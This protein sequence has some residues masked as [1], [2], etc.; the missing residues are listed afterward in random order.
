ML[1][2]ISGAMGGVIFRR[3]NKRGEAIIA[4]RPRKSNTQPSEAQKA[5]RERF[6]QAI[7]YAKAALADP[8]Q[9]LRYEARATLCK[10]PY[11][12]AISDYFNNVILNEVKNL[13]H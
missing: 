4:Q 8:E 9:R 6:A 7:A 10:T 13:S 3:S 2:G 1:A 12:L 5:Q 11:N